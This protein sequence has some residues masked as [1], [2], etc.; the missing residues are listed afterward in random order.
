MSLP[1]QV[2]DRFR[3]HDLDQQPEAQ[4]AIRRVREEFM[5]TTENMLRDVPPGRE[6]SIAL[7][8]LE[9][10]CFF[11]VAGIARAYGVPQ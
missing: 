5:Q 1:H 7:T 10:A 3:P 4:R 11:A 6:L 9:E 2:L 8:K